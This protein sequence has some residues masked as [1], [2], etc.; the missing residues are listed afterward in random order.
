MLQRKD[1]FTLIFGEFCDR[2]NY[3]GIQSVL[4]LYLIDSFLFSKNHSITLYGVYSSLGFISPI[5]GGYFADRFSCRHKFVLLGILLILCG[6]YFLLFNTQDMLFLGFALIIA[7]IGLFKSNNAVLFGSL[8]NTEPNKKDA[9]FTLYYASMNAGAIA[10]PA[11]YG[12]LALTLGWKCGFAASIIGFT[13]CLIFYLLRLKHFIKAAQAAQRISRFIL[14]KMILIGAG[15]CAG[16][17][18]C[19]Q[20]NQY[21]NVLIAIS[22]L[23]IASYLLYLI[24]PL[25]KLDKRKLALLILAMCFGLFF[26]AV[27]L[28]VSSTLLLYITEDVNTKLFGFTIPSQYFMSLYPLLIIL[29]APFLA[30]YWTKHSQKNG[31]SS[32]LIS[33]INLSLY[34]A[35]ASFIILALSAIVPNQF[36]YQMLLILISLLVLAIGELAIGPIVTSAVTYLAPEKQH[37]IFMG[38][39]YL[40]IGYSAYASSLIA[41]LMNITGSEHNA[42]FSMF[43]LVGGVTLCISAAM[44][45]ASKRL[46]RLD[47]N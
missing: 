21:F 47:P 1:A 11:V 33:R 6:D 45:L 16:V 39:W 14:P 34:L 30:K 7:G 38:L 22:V 2:F 12:T 24:K 9:A 27:S 44:T 23:L 18:F 35:A 19:F 13:V 25:P 36:H 28:Q 5:I 37:G 26:Y 32:A 43:I 31:R 46:A 3:Y 40:F 15:L 17:Y 41:K 10:G 4:I 20:F 42:Y 29:S 8:Y